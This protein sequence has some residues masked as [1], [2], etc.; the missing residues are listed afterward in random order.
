MKMS[1]WKC[2]YVS[3]VYEHKKFVN[4]MIANLSGPKS[5]HHHRIVFANIRLLFLG[6]KEKKKEKESQDGDGLS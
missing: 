5:N 6:K 1:F 2:S 3:G 4:V